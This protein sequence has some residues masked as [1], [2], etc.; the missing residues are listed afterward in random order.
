M[1][2]ADGKTA[3]VAAS[4]DAP[5]AVSAPCGM[6]G[7][8]GILYTCGEQTGG[9][10]AVA[11]ALRGRKV[12]GMCGAYDQFVVLAD[13]WE[14]EWALSIGGD[15]ENQQVA[16]GLQDVKI[17]HVAVGENH[18]VALSLDGQLFSWGRSGAALTNGE[19]GHLNG[20]TSR[21][22]RTA[23]P[24]APESDSTEKR[25]PSPVDSVQS[26]DTALV[27]T[28]GAIGV[29]HRVLTA[30]ELFFTQVACGKRH[31]VAITDNG[32]VY[33]WGRNFEGQLGRVFTTLP[34]KLNAVLNG[35]CAWPKYVSSL[36][37]KPRAVSVCCGDTF[38]IVLLSDG[39]VY[40]LGD[41]SSGVAP[42]RLTV[43][44][45]ST[46]PDA[47]NTCTSVLNLMLTR[48]SEGEPFVGI[49]CGYAHV[50]AV[51][52]VGEA[53][54]WG[55]NTF[56]QLGHGRKA[57]E[58]DV[59]VKEDMGVPKVVQCDSTVKW[60]K[61]FAGGNYSAAL[62]TDHQLYTWGN[63]NHGKLGHGKGAAT[64][65]G[66]S[67]LPSK[68]ANE[69][70][71]RRV[72]YFQHTNISSVVCGA[73][74]L[75]AFAPTYVSSLAPL[76]GE[77]SGS[78]ELRLRGSGFWATDDL[79][80]RF[81]PL[82]DGHLMRGSFGTFCEATGEIVCQV[83]KFRLP[84]EFAVEVSM[85]G[86]HFTSN[87]RIFTVFKRPQVAAVSI[88]D[89]RFSGGEEIALALSGNLP[90]L[91]QRPILRFVCC[92]VDA[93][94]G[95]VVSMEMQDREAPVVI[96]VFDEC[97][98][99][100]DGD[101]ET[102]RDT[103]S[104]TGRMLR[105]KTPAIAVTEDEIVPYTLEISYDDGL[106]FS[107]VCVD[108][109]LMK[110]LIAKDGEIGEASDEEES[111]LERRSYPHKHSQS[112]SPRPALPHVIWM[113]EARLLRVR[114]N[115]FLMNAL[116]QTIELELHHLLPP[117]VTSLSVSIVHYLRNGGGAEVTPE[118]A[119]SVSTDLH[120]ENIDDDIVTCTIPPLLQWG[121]P[122]SS[123]LQTPPNEWWKT[124]AK[125]GFT[126]QLRIS[127]NGGRSFLPAQPQNGKADAS[128]AA[129]V[130]AVYAMPA[131]GR[132]LSLFP[133]VGLVSGGTQVAVAGETLYFDTQDAAVALQWRE[134]RVIVPAVC[135]SPDVSV[136]ST[137]TRDSIDRRVVFRTPQLPFPNDASTAAAMAEG[138]V[139]GTREEVE[140][141][142]ALDGVHFA[143]IGLRFVYCAVP[144]VKSITPSEAEPGTKMVLAVDKVVAT[145]AACVRLTAAESQV[146]L[147]VPAEIVEAS[148]T[149][150]FVLPELPLGSGQQVH[151]ALSLNGQEFVEGI[152]D[153]TAAASSAGVSFCYKLPLA[154]GR[155]GARV[156]TELEHVAKILGAA[157]QEG[158]RGEAIQRLED[159]VEQHIDKVDAFE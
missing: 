146:S 123:G 56:G 124:Y 29:P 142:V 122:T 101:E 24:T 92:C 55:L 138:M 134:S 67:P 41:L 139:L 99:S 153:A 143:D 39:S 80:V 58:G 77:L 112:E 73:R 61:V 36:L 52:S 62:T 11:D 121:A 154:K 19:L 147:V 141:F 86:K 113:H 118:L 53:F 149:A 114:P 47:N 70:A 100:G 74:N 94:S 110:L 152:S 48:G 33:T 68:Y 6:E 91:C 151:V 50:L 129:Q 34:K 105:L 132:L 111:S 106:H 87:G 88:S 85:N 98:E 120:I 25:S 2:R 22:S 1:R 20:R 5:K 130:Y 107:P 148:H 66:P 49:A 3:D 95:E 15:N 43:D 65:A 63:S 145:P 37:G 71:P 45:P 12:R 102:K 14:L 7:S 21:G 158:M 84:G 54:S 135:L 69:F 136:M 126:S 60:A 57:E 78:Y 40:R 79:T 76:C 38:T 59:K 137:A 104:L 44:S 64:A 115:S 119:L 89:A 150:L 133:D 30:P 125:T 32:D 128:I 116:P 81:V 83:P 75:F 35:I 26:H 23:T 127:M 17:H 140:V 93:E 42:P 144:E 28:A 96:G 90:E 9:E 82:I 51:T 156:F 103:S 131:P 46:S 13:A 109:T 4:I 10:I 157:E 16:Q 97:P 117:E 159:K 8:L 72:E 108:P 31:S 27:D 18:R 155:R